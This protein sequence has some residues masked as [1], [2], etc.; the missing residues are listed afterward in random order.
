MT[1]TSRRQLLLQGSHSVLCSHAKNC[2]Q[3]HL[4]SFSSVVSALSFCDVLTGGTMRSC[5]SRRPGSQSAAPSS[6]AA[7]GGLH[8]CAVSCEKYSS[9]CRVSPAP[10]VGFRMS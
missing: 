1:L 7:P 5:T 4:K 2:L 8:R 3:S 6:G 9:C 10:G